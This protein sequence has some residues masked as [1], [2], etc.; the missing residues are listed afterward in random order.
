MYTS[1]LQKGFNTKA[2]IPVMSPE[3]K[4]LQHRAR[5]SWQSPFNSKLFWAG[6]RTQPTAT[7]SRE[8]REAGHA[9][10]YAAPAALSSRVQKHYA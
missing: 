1:L 10:G 8:Q 9:V 5:C 7:G 6:K 3:V 4:T 2:N